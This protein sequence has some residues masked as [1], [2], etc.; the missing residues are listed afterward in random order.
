M[1]RG[2]RSGPRLPIAPPSPPQDECAVCQ[3]TATPGNKIIVGLWGV[4][5]FNLELP[6]CERCIRY[7]APRDPRDADPLTLDVVA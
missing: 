3:S 5:R 4:I 1:E 7:Y 6:L 2:W